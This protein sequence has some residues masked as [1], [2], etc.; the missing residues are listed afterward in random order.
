[1]TEKRGQVRTAGWGIA[2]AAVI[3]AGGAV[4]AAPEV[5]SERPAPT[6]FTALMADEKPKPDGKPTAQKTTPAIPRTSVLAVLVPGVD[7]APPLRP[8]TATQTRLPY[9]ADAELWIDRT[10]AGVPVIP[11][12]RTGAI[13][14]MDV[15]AFRP[16]NDQMTLDQAAMLYSTLQVL[17]PAPR[18]VME[19]VNP[20]IPPAPAGAPQ[21]SET[22]RVYRGMVPGQVVVLG[23]AQDLRTRALLIYLVQITGTV[24]NPEALL[25]A[26]TVVS[27]YMLEERGR[28]SQPPI[29]PGSAPVRPIVRFE[30][31][32]IQELAQS[33]ER[34]ATVSAQVKEIAR[35]VLMQSSGVMYGAWQTS[36]PLT[37][38][39]FFDF[40]QTQ[41]QKLGW[42]PA[43]S[44]D[45][46]QPGHPTLLLQRPHNDG[47]VLV[48]A[49]PTARPV[50]GKSGGP[51]TTVVVLVIEGSINV[52]ALKPRAQ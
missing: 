46:T 47:V 15:L 11:G 3:A 42:G 16:K 32:R 51:S 19:L 44:R 4:S 24:G 48:R 52:S 22:V 18:P 10:P 38:Q 13:R 7:G 25:Q 35:V 49:E 26:K 8:L 5:R 39:A 34:S 43:I 23:S 29:P 12:L 50:L 28:R 14:R 17:S 1:M 2:W 37:D 40:Y 6:A 33:I 20:P 41:T 21:T 9:P 30:G 27:G 45:E 36:A 31:P